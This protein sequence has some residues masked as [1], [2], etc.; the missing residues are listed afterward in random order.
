MIPALNEAE[1]L[2]HV[3]ATLPADTYELVLVD[4]HSIDGTSTVAREHYPNVRIV[5]QS[6]RGK[7]DALRAGF[8]A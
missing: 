1:N 7:G 3:L 8:D 2:P 6:G 4:G 5:S